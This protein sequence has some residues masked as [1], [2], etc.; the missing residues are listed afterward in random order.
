[1][2]VRNPSLA[3]LLTPPGP[4]LATK[5]VAEHIELECT[6]L[7]VLLHKQGQ[8]KVACIYEVAAAEAAQNAVDADG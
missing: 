6:L 2:P 4:E 8:H 3:A 5:L 1:M 7:A